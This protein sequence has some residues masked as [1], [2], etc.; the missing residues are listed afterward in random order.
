MHFLLL[1]VDN[2]IITVKDRLP[3]ECL[4]CTLLLPYRNE[5]NNV[6]NIHKG[7]VSRGSGRRTSKDFGELALV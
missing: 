2:D 1:I 6:K 5:I 7:T 4:A 3:Y